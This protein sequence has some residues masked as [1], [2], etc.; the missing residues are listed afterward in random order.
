MKKYLISLLGILF[1]INGCALTK[2]SQI[3]GLDDKLY[4][5]NDG[6]IL[7]CEC[8]SSFNSPL[9]W[10]CYKKKATKYERAAFK[11]P[12]FPVESIP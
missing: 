4:K 7:I 11:K 2:S 10:S 9:Y 3:V 5:L 8:L 1:F 12:G 6:E